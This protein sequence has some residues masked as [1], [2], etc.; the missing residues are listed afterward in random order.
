MEIVEQNESSSTW[1]DLFTF[2][3]IA[4]STVLFKRFKEQGEDHAAFFQGVVTKCFTKTNHTTQPNQ[5]ENNPIF[6]K[7]NDVVTEVTFPWEP[8]VGNGQRTSCPVSESFAITQTVMST[9]SSSTSHL[10]TTRERMKFISTM[11]FASNFQVPCPC[12]K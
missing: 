12:C 11:T 7:K 3:G 1:L 8:D 4:V 10:Q 2:F 6:L 9:P 5:D